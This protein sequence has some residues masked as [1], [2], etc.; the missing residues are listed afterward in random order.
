MRDNRDN[1]ADSL[2]LN[3][4]FP[5]NT[6]GRISK[7][8]WESDLGV[9][10]TD[11]SDYAQVVNRRWAEML[12]YN[13]EEFPDDPSYWLKIVHPDDYNT[14]I[15]AIN[16]HI[17]G[18]SP[19]YE[20]EFRM[21]CRD[22]TWKWIFSSGKVSECDDSGKPTRISGVHLDI[23]DRVSVKNAIRESN[24]KLNLFSGVIRH[25]VMNQLTAAFGYADLLHSEIDGGSDAAIYLKSIEKALDN[26]HEQI[27]FTK[28]IS[29]LG[30]DDPSW[31]PFCRIIEKSVDETGIINL[32]V[33]SSVDDL[34]ILGD[35]LFYRIYSVL[36]E[37]AIRHSKNSDL[38]VSIDFREGDEYAVMT[39]SDNGCG[40]PDDQ[41]ALIFEKGFGEGSGL[42]LFLVKELLMM[43]NMQVCECGVY[44]NGCI[45]EILMPKGTYKLSRAVR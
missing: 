21:L 1:N 24:R 2:P 18:D 4:F 35:V 27:T 3:N 14:V 32:I 5:E 13:P 33:D 7:A 28:S 10:D 26:I 15:D 30:S 23:N 34:N 36:F 22:G 19:Y 11:L 43:H 38:T 29:M 9:W 31:Q 12:G 20:A 44:G 37:N 41:K 8:I 6:E 42:G 16:S 17:S 25:D 45:F 40:V 39:V